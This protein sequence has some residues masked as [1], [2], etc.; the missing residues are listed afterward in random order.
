M[1]ERQHEVV[2]DA[3]LTFAHILKTQ[4]PGR[5]DGKPP[6]VCVFEV[7]DKQTQEKAKAEGQ[8]LLSVILVDV[9]R[10]Q[11]AQ[12]SE[13]PI[14]REEDEQGNI[15]EYKCGTPTYIMPRYLVTPWSGDPLQDQVVL[16]L[17]MQVFFARQQ[18][19]PEDIQGSSIFGE[20][21]PMVMLYE[22]FNLERQMKLWQVMGHAYRPSVVYGVNLVMESMQKQV[23]RRVKERILDFKKLEG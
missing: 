10:S 5:L 21:G 8:V 14:I 17:I 18:F 16:G 3:T 2:R 11:I 4:L 6:V 9:G 20:Q 19:R 1:R 7:P 12:T 15:V 22:A 13:Q 23:V